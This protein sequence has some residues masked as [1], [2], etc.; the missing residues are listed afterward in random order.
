MFTVKDLRKMIAQLPQD[1][2]VKQM[3]PF[4]L[5]QRPPASF[6]IKAGIKDG[7]DGVARTA[8]SKAQ[9]ISTN[10]LS[11]LFEFDTLNITTLPPMQSEDTLVVGRLPDCDV[12]VEHA[13]VS[14]R[15]A[16]LR[17]NE[18]DKRCT[19]KDDGSTNG[20]FV[21]DTSIGAREATLRDGDIVTFGEVPFWF[22][23][24][25]TL[26]SKLSTRSTSNRLG[27]RSG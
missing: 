4:A 25:T 5:V 17:W 3:G 8:M 13:S 14:K 23:L 21:N 2:F 16:S 15:H 10:I 1:S 26:Y 27:S 12:V 24:T 22:L 11:L 9:D 18:K 19:V 6:L 20:T 7:E